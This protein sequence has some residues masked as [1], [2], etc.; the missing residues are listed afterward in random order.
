VGG[1]KILWQ[2]MDISGQKGG[3]LSGP[4]CNW[5]FVVCLGSCC[6]S[7]GA[8]LGENE[9]RATEQDS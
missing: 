9:H 4:M 2:V 5:Q 8:A 3:Y 1:K 7:F 6:V